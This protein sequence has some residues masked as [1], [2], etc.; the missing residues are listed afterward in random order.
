MSQ[1]Q[2]DTAKD[3]VLDLLGWGVPPEYLVNCGLS[4]EIIY[5]VFVDFNLRLPSNLDLAGLPPLPYPR[6]LHYTSPEPI[7]PPANISNRQRSQSNTSSSRPSHGHPSLPQKPSAPL[8]TLSTE[9]STLSATALPFL[10]GPSV[11]A[12]SST[13]LI[14]MELQR[15]QEL[16]ARKHLVNKLKQVAP[17]PPR[18]SLE[19]R[20][21]EPKD[22]E[23]TPS[24][25][26]VP[27]QTVDD[28]L[29]SIGPGTPVEK[30]REDEMDVDDPIPGLS[31]TSDVPIPPHSSPRRPEPH[32]TSVS[33]SGPSNDVSFQA[34]S[35]NGAARDP[36][37]E[38][39]AYERRSRS[40]SN[41][42]SDTS[43]SQAREH[44]AGLRRGTKRPVAA[45]FVDMDS[46][47]SRSHYHGYNDYHTGRHGHHHHRRRPQSFAGL[48]GNRRMV[49]H[50]SDTSEDEEDEDPDDHAH[51]SQGHVRQPPRLGITVSGPVVGSMDVVPT[52]S[53][54]EEKEQE[55]QKMRELIARR[56][57]A[58]LDKLAAVSLPCP[59][60][61]F[62][63]LTWDS[64]S[65][66]LQVHPT[67]SGYR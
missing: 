50:L 21:S 14:D 59:C 55:I 23:M 62:V 8:G 32:P 28:F 30:H 20:L 44:S 43:E 7:S 11:P 39:R 56:E 3:I 10:P 46:G 57:R 63:F 25:P 34:Q 58:R 16:L 2:Y 4:R 36:S 61:L 47:P 41:D 60:N 19:S 51:R 66:F 9:T 45:D 5:Y 40:R 24:T 29:K 35:E 65:E 26:A 52:R 49:I 18:A 31:Y 33:T 67:W 54:V 6:N 1:S 12:A 22:V 53:A 48:S 15:R 37:V 27:K 42:K 13:D 64:V 38:R 17:V